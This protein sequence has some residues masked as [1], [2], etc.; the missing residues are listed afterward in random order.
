MATPNPLEAADATLA[1]AR[2]R[3]SDVVT[4]ESATSPFDADSTQEIPRETASAPD[5]ESTQELPVCGEFGPG[6]GWRSH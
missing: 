5:P 1:R 3:R 2:A 6:L 4:P